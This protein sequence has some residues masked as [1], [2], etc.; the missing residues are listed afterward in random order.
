MVTLLVDIGQFIIRFHK[1]LVAP[2][3]EVEGQIKKVDDLFVIFDCYFRP[4]DLNTWQTS[5][6][7][8]SISFGV[9]LQ[10]ARPSS[11]YRPTSFL[12]FGASKDNM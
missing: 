9:A 1:W 8:F 6:L 5:C 11:W 10:I 3:C 4:F 12:N 2:I 7:G